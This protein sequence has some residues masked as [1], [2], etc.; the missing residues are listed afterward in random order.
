MHDHTMTMIRKHHRKHHRRAALLALALALGACAPTIE[1]RGS[2][3]SNLALS[4]LET[5]TDGKAEVTAA[6]GSPAATATFQDNIWYYM[7][8]RTRQIAF[9]DPKVL[10][11]RIVAIVFDDRDRI[12][13]VVTYTEADGKE[14]RI[15]SRETP[16]EGTD[17]TLLQQLFGN[18][19]KFVDEGRV[20]DSITGPGVPR[21]GG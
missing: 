14:V 10:E 2:I 17:F 18:F 15:V 11:R 3:P 9:F 13:D 16:T 1:N 6:L 19:G 20:S 21:P 12:A 7:G 4:R 8:E 5:G